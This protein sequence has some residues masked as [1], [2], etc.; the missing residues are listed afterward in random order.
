MNDRKYPENPTL[1]RRTC[2]TKGRIVVYFPALNFALASQFGTGGLTAIV[3]ATPHAALGRA[4]IRLMCPDPSRD[5]VMDD[6]AYN[7]HG[8]PGTWRYP[9]QTNDFFTIADDGFCEVDR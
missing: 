7:K 8:L 3:V 4:T 1:N 6:V 5:M 9:E 2:P